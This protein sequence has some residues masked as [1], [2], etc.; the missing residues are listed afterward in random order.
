MCKTTEQPYIIPRLYYL[1]GKP[2]YM[3]KVQFIDGGMLIQKRHFYGHNEN[4]KKV[5][6]CHHII[7]SLLKCGAMELVDN[8]T[9]GKEWA[10]RI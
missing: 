7:N 9:G 4:F 6:V 8:P 3:Y 10:M 1:Q 2:T 5:Q